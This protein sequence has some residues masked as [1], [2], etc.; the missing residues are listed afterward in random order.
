MLSDHVYPAEAVA[1]IYLLDQIYVSL[2][3]ESDLWT[4][5][6]A[7]KAELESEIYIFLDSTCSKGT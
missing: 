3:N 7:L 1:A 5:T 2:S 4:L 6:C